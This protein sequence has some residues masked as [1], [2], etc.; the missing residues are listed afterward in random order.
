M[1]HQQ[2]HQFYSLP[3]QQQQ[4]QQPIQYLQPQYQQQYQQQF[5]HPTQYKNDEEFKE[6]KSTFKDSAQTEDGYVVRFTISN[7]SSDSYVLFVNYM[8]KNASFE[9]A[10]TV[11]VHP[12]GRISHILDSESRLCNY[13]LLENWASLASHRFRASYFVYAIYK[14]FLDNPPTISPVEAEFKQ[15]EDKHPE[16]AKMSDSEL[17]AMEKNPQQIKSFALGKDNTKNDGE[18]AK[19]RGDI[20]RIM[21]E[22]ENEIMPQTRKIDAEIE[23]QKA[24]YAALQKEYAEALERYN[25]LRESI[26]VAGARTRLNAALDE[27]DKELRALKGAGPCDDLNAYAEKYKMLNMAYYKINLIL[28]PLEN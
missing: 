2:Q 20:S 25:K 24:E 5:V 14:F 16:L 21:A 26:D 6:L 4:Q 17:F 23:G 9:N 12:K 1:Y 27:I 19:L 3:P 10:P 15:M 11:Q 7:S 28:K 13:N 18:I 8:K 22:V